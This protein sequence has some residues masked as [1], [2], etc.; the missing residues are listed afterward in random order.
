MIEETIQPVMDMFISLLPIILVM[1]LLG[2]LM[3]SFAGGRR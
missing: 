1:M 2:G 3:K